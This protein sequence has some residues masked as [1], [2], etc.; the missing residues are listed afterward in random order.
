VR[1]LVKHVALFVAYGTLCVVATLVGVY[2]H[3]LKSQPDLQ[4]WHTR[5][6]DAEF[7]AADVATV[8]TLDDYR[9]L[10]DRVFAQLQEKVYA[11]VAASDRRAINRYSPGSLSDPTPHRPDWNR[12]FELAVDAPR[13]GAVLLHGLTD[14]PYTMRAIAQRL[15]AKGY[16]VVGLRLPGHGTA[17]S[18]ILYADWEDWAA[19]TRLAARHVRGRIGPDRPLHLVGYSS[20]A[21]LAV[22]YAA[23]RLQGEDL[24]R[25][26]SLVLLSPAI[27]VSRAAALANVQSALGRVDGFEKAAWTAIVPEYDPFKYNSFTAHAGDQIHRVTRRIDT[28]LTALGGGAPVRGMPRILAF[29]SVADATVSTPAVVN[30]LFRRLAPEGHALVFFDINRYAEAEPLFTP[31]ARAVRGDL[32]D[33]PPLPFDLTAIVNE[34]AAS[35][36]VVALHRRAG[37]TGTTREATG[38]AWPPS[39]F[40]LSHIALPFP[41]DDPVY[42]TARPQAPAL[43]FLGRPELLGERGLLA[44]SPVVLMRLRHNPFFAYVEKRLDE[45]L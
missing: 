16:W 9:R 24:P 38:L 42:G 35:A 45:F 19:A 39:V 7:R 37:T 32:L 4:A 31:A 22:E 23:A 12:T 25:V 14:A 33:G 43:I 36:A 15:H 41:P 5:E 6:L 10:E 3:F 20:G 34:D 2:L 13:G 8:K 40:S 30:A 11:T 1:R 28:Q 26:D 44:V 29:Q 27:G 17:P 21:G 18:G